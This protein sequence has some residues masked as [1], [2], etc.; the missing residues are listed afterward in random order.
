MMTV[1]VS[2]YTGDLKSWLIWPNFMP[3]INSL[4][5]LVDRD[6]K[7][8]ININSPLAN[9]ILVRIVLNFLTLV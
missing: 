7:I 3:I 4:D 5:E 8:T 2:A 9:N 1:L 6:V